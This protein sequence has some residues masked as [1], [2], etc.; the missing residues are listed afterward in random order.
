[1]VVFFDMTFI[2]ALG[3]SV[4][5]RVVPLLRSGVD[6][7][8]VGRDITNVYYLNFLIRII[9]NKMALLSVY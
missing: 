3:N 1:M 6:N 2:Y 4:L 9:F 7:R 5:R 8:R